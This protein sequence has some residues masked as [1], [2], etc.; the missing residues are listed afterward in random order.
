MWCY[1]FW[2]DCW[3]CGSTE[4]MSILFFLDTGCLFSIS[5]GKNPDSDPWAWKCST[6]PAGR[7]S[8]LFLEQCCLLYPSLWIF[9]T[10]WQHSKKTGSAWSFL[11]SAFL[12]PH[13]YSGHWVISFYCRK[14]RQYHLTVINKTAFISTLCG[15]VKQQRDSIYM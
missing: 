6:Q 9:K 14:L 10:I 7:H 11:D 3:K 4:E 12:F 13:A 5:A 8:L 15:G 2:G 1:Y